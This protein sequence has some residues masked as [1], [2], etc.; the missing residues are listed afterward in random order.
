[1]VNAAFNQPFRFQ[2]APSPPKGHG[3]LIRFMNFTAI[4]L[5]PELEADRTKACS[6]VAGFGQR[7]EGVLALN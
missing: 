1:M 2:A 7:H 5:T 4:S 3:A 6:K